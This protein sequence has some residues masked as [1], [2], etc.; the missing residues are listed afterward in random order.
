MGVQLAT[1]VCIIVWCAVL[2]YLCLKIINAL[3]GLRFPFQE[4]LLGAD[5][6]EHSIG[7]RKYDKV[8]KRLTDT[9][10]LRAYDLRRRK[11]YNASF[12][13]AEHYLSQK[14]AGILTVADGV[15]PPS[16]R[17][18]IKMTRTNSPPSPPYLKR[19][20]LYSFHN[21]HG[22]G[23]ASPSP[24]RKDLL[25]NMNASSPFKRGAKERRSSLKK[26]HGAFRRKQIHKAPKWQQKLGVDNLAYIEQEENTVN[27][28]LVTKEMGE[29]SIG[30]R[31]K[32]RTSN[33]SVKVCE[34]NDDEDIQM[35]DINVAVV[36]KRGLMVNSSTQTTDWWTQD[37]ECVRCQRD[38]TAGKVQDEGGTRDYDDDEMLHDSDEYVTTILRNDRMN[39]GEESDMADDVEFSAEDVT[40][41]ED[42]IETVNRLCDIQYEE[43]EYIV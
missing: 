33:V 9:S 26:I 21:G 34:I 7:P 31:Y 35:N 41:K 3:V 28:F 36:Q 30:E 16:M 18:K 27:G 11:K 12:R 38:P 14:E 4:E 8:K 15:E 6:V 24:R 2:S 20:E 32:G 10:R 22:N 17:K 13:A 1:A 19:S 25:N 39:D 42:V 5:I 37:V 29:Y 23:R 40:G 43:V